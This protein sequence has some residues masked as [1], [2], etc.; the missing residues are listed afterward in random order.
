MAEFGVTPQGFARKRLPDILADIEADARLAFGAGVIQ[1]PQSPLGQWNGL[2]ASLAASVWELAEATY[3]SLDPDQAEAVR[4][5][6]LARLRL[7]ERI[8]GES[9]EAFRAAITNAGR[10]R[11][12]LADIYRAVRNVAGVTWAKVWVNDTAS[13]D[14]NGIPP[15]T[16]A[17]AAL[18]GA[19]AD[20]VAA[21][22]LYIVPGIGTYGNVQASATI[23][24]FCRSMALARPAERPVKLAL[25]VSVAADRLGC[26]P[27]TTVAMAQALVEQLSGDARP[28]NGEDVDLHMLQMAL[29]CRFPNVR[30]TAA[31]ASVDPAAVAPLPL[32]LGFFEIA[33]FDVSRITITVA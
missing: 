23:D 10:A 4:L 13:T 21:A 18:G 11:I 28:A 2:A 32:A 3:Q 33:A 19:D 16:L 5:D 14:A 12:D 27:P 25:T 1:T 20:I 31:Q 26:P 22:R 30:I 8:P 7:I 17:I 24:G 29:S 15:N 9:D 6:M